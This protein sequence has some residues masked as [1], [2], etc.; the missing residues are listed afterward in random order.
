MAD[1]SITAA[2]VGINNEATVRAVQVGE[3]VTQG[4]LGYKNT[5]DGKYYK[6]DANDTEAKA[7][8]AVVFLT[9]AAIN[10]W[11]V[12]AFPG[13]EIIIGA[14]VVKNT[15][16]A[17][18]VTAGSVCLQ[19]DLVSGNYITPIGTATSTTVIPFKPNATGVTV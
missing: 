9:P 15:P 8:A 17:V 14:T 4:Q 6:T 5:S 7:E 12:A 3:A 1:L 13:S 16:Y 2:N 11:S 19:S 10:G 18:S